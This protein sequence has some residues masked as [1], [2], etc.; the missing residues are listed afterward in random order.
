MAAAGP[1]GALLPGAGRGS[2]RAAGRCPGR[3]GGRPRGAVAMALAELYT[4]VSGDLRGERPE[5]GRP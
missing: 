1:P 5:G 3:A 2:G 4:Q